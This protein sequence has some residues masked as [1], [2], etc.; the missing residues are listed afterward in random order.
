[1]PSLLRP[2]LPLV[3]DLPSPLMA[4]LSVLNT[5]VHSKV[6]GVEERVGKRG[7]ARWREN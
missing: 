4:I 5:P 3:G 1:M 6:N 2:M 7:V